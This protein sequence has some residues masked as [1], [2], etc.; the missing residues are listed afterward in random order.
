MRHI[1]TNKELYRS[2]RQTWTLK[3]VTKVKQSG[4]I[5]TRKIKHAGRDG[6]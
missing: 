5:Y 2:L 1:K 6:R 4:K 3:P